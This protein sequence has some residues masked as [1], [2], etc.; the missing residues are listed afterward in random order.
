MKSVFYLIVTCGAAAFFAG[1]IVLGFIDW[2]TH[3]QS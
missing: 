1:R 2:L 3:K